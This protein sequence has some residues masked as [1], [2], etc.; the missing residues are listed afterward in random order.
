MNKNVVTGPV[1]L[2]QTDRNGVNTFFAADDNFPHLF[3]AV[4]F[5]EQIADIFNFTLKHHHNDVCN[6]RIVLHGAY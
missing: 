1:D 6:A 3:H 2:L 5:F 4:V